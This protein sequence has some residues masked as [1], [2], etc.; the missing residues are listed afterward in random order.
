MDLGLDVADGL[1]ALHQLG[2]VHGDIKPDNVLM[3]EDPKRWTAKIADF[4]HSILDTGETRHLIGGTQAYAAPEWKEKLATG[5]LLKTDVYSY[6]L[7][8]GSIMAGFDV[9]QHFLGLKKHG[10]TLE[11]RLFN[12]EHKKKS[13]SIRTFV[14]E[15]I[16][17]AEG[18]DL[19]S[20]KDEME[21]A[22]SLI[23]NALDINA[24]KRD[25]RQFLLWGRPESLNIHGPTNEDRFQKYANS[26]KTIIQTL[27]ADIVNSL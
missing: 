26:T 10:R 4:S 20:R 23:S 21:A 12:L 9:I 3:F 22:E 2:V 13:G 16:Y 5:T 25:L 17:E 11:E 14:T 6:G 19:I 8:F 1:L 15:L 24:D 7:L 27:D 18:A